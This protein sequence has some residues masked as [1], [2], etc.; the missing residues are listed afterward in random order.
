MVRTK[1]QRLIRWP[2]LVM[3]MV[4][5]TTL[6]AEPTKKTD[7]PLPAC[8]D[9][10]VACCPMGYECHVA[11][12]GKWLDIPKLAKIDHKLAS[13]SDEIAVLKLSRP[14]R[15]GLTVG[16]GGTV[17]PELN[18][19]TTGVTGAIGVSVVWGFRINP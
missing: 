17:G 5:W 9:K 19:G 8:G 13:Q 7:I 10:A 16:P 11:G 12:T 18:G 15:W 4:C 14:K 2:T 1:P 6:C 3:L